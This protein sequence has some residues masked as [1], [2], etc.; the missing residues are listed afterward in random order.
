MWATVTGRWKATAKYRD[1]GRIQECTQLEPLT[2]GLGT[3]NITDSPANRSNCTRSAPPSAYQ[4]YEL[5]RIKDQSA[6]N[7]V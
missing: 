4:V 1:A 6:A 5:W 2:T 7:G 3:V